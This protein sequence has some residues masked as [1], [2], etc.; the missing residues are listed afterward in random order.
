MVENILPGLGV[1]DGPEGVAV[2]ALD[3]NL[4]HNK[5]GLDQ[6]KSCDS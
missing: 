4:E 2:G 5:N 3:N 1:E 6:A